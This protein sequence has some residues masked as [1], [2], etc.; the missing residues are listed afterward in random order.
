MAKFLKGLEKAIRKESD[1]ALVVAVWLTDDAAKTKDYLPR[2]QQSL[3]FEA[4]ALTCFDVDKAGPA[5]W[6]VNADAHITVVVATQSK[7]A[8]TLGY[9][10][11]NETEV[12][13]VRDALVKALKSK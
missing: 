3:Q 4:T 13:A 8:A 7:V 5:S 9:R 11:I 1:D 2:A 12:P 6:G 10:S